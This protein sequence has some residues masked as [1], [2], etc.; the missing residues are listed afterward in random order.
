MESQI[1]DF[2]FTRKPRTNKLSAEEVKWIYDNRHN[3]EPLA[4]VAGRFGVSVATV[5]SIRRGTRKAMVTGAVPVV[6]KAPLTRDEI[7]AIIG[8][9]LREKGDPEG[10]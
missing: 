10:L 3:K 5:C 1:K 8:H 2:S 6:R 9:P 7:E 4:V